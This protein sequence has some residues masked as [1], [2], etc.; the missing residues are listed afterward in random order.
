MQLRHVLV[1]A[2]VA[3][4]QGCNPL[5]QLWAAKVHNWTP[6]ALPAHFPFSVVVTLDW[7]APT[8]AGL[9]LWAADGK[10]V[11]SADCELTKSSSSHAIA[12]LPEVTCPTPPLAPGSYSMRFSS[13]RSCGAKS[14][15]PLEGAIDVIEPAHV[16][17]AS[18]AHGPEKASTSIKVSGT[19]LGGPHM[20]CRF[21]FPPAPGAKF[22]C[23]MT[24]AGDGAFEVTATSAVCQVP[25]WPGPMMQE[26][27]DHT[28]KPVEGAV[29]SREVHVQITNDARVWSQKPLVFRYDGAEHVLV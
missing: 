4:C 19:N 1:A 15:A 9:T 26:Q 21:T 13:D 3:A 7:G 6:G 17:A 10:Q 16:A 23:D 18:P 5:K 14:Y 25:A 24:E 11:A 20:G 27:A 28:L 8:A 29:C 2:G 12:D 22:G